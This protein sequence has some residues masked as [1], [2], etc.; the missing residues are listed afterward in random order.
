MTEGHPKDRRDA[1]RFLKKL[2]Q[3]N[4][5]SFQTFDDS[6]DKNKELTRVLHGSLEENFPLLGQLNDQGAGIFVTVNETDLKGRKT[7]NII[8]V[9]AVFA[10]LD[11]APLE[12]VRDFGLKPHIIIETSPNRWHA[13]WPRLL[14]NSVEI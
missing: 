7:D 14:K 9:R 6:D 10:D 4:R 3:D 13:Y 8:S 12:P 2:D 5:F 1:H 11:A